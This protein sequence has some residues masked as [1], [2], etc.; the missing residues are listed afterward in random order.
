MD[1]EEL[2]LRKLIR[3]FVKAHDIKSG[4]HPEESYDKELLDDS[5]FND[6]SVYV[7]DDIKKKIKKWAKDMGLSTSKK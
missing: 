6:G 1:K 4:S 5:S 3:E 2:T 7:P